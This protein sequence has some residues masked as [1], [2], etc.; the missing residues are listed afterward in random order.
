MTEGNMP[1]E[2]IFGRTI[3]EIEKMADF[4]FNRLD[5]NHPESEKGFIKALN[6]GAEIL[7]KDAEF[8]KNFKNRDV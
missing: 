4:V 2:R 8:V 1:E 3:P 5:A 6:E 7:G